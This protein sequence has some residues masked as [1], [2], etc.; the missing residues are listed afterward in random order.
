MSRSQAPSVRRQRLGVALR[1]LREE[2]GLTADKAGYRLGWSASKISR[3]ETAGISVRVSDVAQ[4]LK[5]YRAGEP[6]SQELIA[7]AREAARPGWWEDYPEIRQQDLSAYIALE[8]EASA[9]FCFQSDIVPG[10]FQTEQYARSLIKGWDEVIRLPPST[11][12]RRLEVR[13]RRQQ[14]LRPPRSLPV[15]AVLDEAVLLRRIGDR[16]TMV[17]QLERLMRLAKESNITIRVLPLDGNHGAAI[18]SFT[19]L[20]FDPENDIEFP[21]WVHVES[22]TAVHAQ[23]E[24]V[25]HEYRLAFEWLKDQSWDR[26]AS[27][28]RIAQ[29]IQHW[30]SLKPF[31]HA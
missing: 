28:A 29:A 23:D 13:M 2:R 15:T 5:L 20:R 14:L 11:L 17:G 16:R 7:L 27:L 19:I 25:T 9:L 26:E 8:D 3:I 24:P 4:M 18:G 6:L 21:D 31:D 30:A 22:A 12:A 1:K 10:L